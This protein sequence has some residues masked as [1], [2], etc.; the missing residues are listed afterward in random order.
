MTM[1]DSPSLRDTL[2]ASSDLDAAVPWILSS[3][4]IVC[5]LYPMRR[6]WSPGS[7]RVSSMVRILW[8]SGNSKSRAL[9][10]ELFPAPRAPQTRM[11]AL[12]FTRNESMPAALGDT[13]P[14]A[15]RRDRVHGRTECFLMATAFP[16]GLRG[17]P[18]MVA[19]ASKS[20]MSVSRT[21]L[22]RQKRSPLCLFR[23]FSRLSTS[24]SSAIRLVEHLMW[25]FRPF[26]PLT[27]TCILFLEHGAST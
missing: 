10:R 16:R 5:T 21:G 25:E 18:M 13:V 7:S 1:A 6:I 15:T 3:T 14:L 2:R 27:V 24:R 23:M 11:V 8:L 22:V 4:S 26:T 19:L 17:Y 20:R 9:S 12:A